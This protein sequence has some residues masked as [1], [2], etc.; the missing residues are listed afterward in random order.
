MRTFNRMPSNV[1]LAGVLLVVFGVSRLLYFKLSHAIIQDAR[2][3]KM[4]SSEKL[5]VTNNTSSLYRFNSTGTLLPAD[6]TSTVEGVT[7]QPA[8]ASIDESITNSNSHHKYDVTGH[9][10]NASVGESITNTNSHHKNY[11]FLHD[12]WEQFNAGKHTLV[13]Y[14][15]LATVTG[16]IPV[17]PFLGSNPAFIGHKNDKRSSH[18]TSIDEFSFG[19]LPTRLENFDAAYAVCHSRPMSVAFVTHARDDSATPC[20]SRTDPILT[21]AESLWGA[22]KNERVCVNTHAIDADLLL[23]KSSSGCMVI[24]AFQGFWNNRGS[25]LWKHSP[26]AV[27]NHYH[28]EFTSTIMSRYHDI[29]VHGRHKMGPLPSHLLR[30]ADCIAGWVRETPSSTIQNMNQNITSD[31]DEYDYDV[32]QFRLEGVMLSVRRSNQ[33]LN[34]SLY[35]ANCV[36]SAV[37]SLEEKQRGSRRPLVVLADIGIHG[38]KSGGISGVAQNPFREMRDLLS[39]VGS[40][41]KTRPSIIHS[42]HQCNRGCL[43]ATCFLLDEAI[44]MMAKTA[45]QLPGGGNSAG[46]MMQTRTMVNKK[47]T[48]IRPNNTVPIHECKSCVM[49]DPHTCW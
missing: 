5:I 38:S 33:G 42:T 16:F 2:V 27:A 17:A 22:T 14:A 12:S 23:K 44:F 25:L 6:R 13:D 15:F 19:S 7:H 3:E 37:H 49:G 34:E 10:I 26:T 18:I 32:L 46:Q 11:L 36:R 20:L 28:W 24:V 31:M 4:S 48:V 47:T 39:F 45:V 29:W 35:I 21:G 43:G 8:N 9:P 41:F 1:S 40:S 30:A